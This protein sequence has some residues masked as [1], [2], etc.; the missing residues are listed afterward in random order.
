MSL[1]RPKEI[2]DRYSDLDI[3]RLSKE[4]YKLILIDIDNTIAY[5]GSGH[6]DDEAKEFVNRI[7]KAGLI[8]VILSNNHKKRVKKFID[9]YDIE[10]HYYGFKPL[11]FR[12][13][14]ICRKNNCKPSQVILIGDQLLTDI[15]GANLSKTYGIYTK[16]LYD[17]DT[18][19]TK[20]NRNLE[21]FIWRN[22]FHEKV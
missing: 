14:S 12:I 21:R 4:G 1:F 17:T 8:P 5:P 7:K 18:P 3:E 22:I 2:L 19:I 20:V 15:L 16:K 9:N 6:F 13:W 10:W 11:P